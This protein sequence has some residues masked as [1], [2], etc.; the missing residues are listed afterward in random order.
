MR[1]LLRI[2]GLDSQPGGP[3]QQPYFDVLAH[4]L[5]RLAESIPGLFKR[6]QIPTQATYAGGI[7]SL[8]WI[9]GLQAFSSWI[10]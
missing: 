10:Y 1:A 4:R 8:E 9:P 6:L 7:D 3:A 2:P 5:H